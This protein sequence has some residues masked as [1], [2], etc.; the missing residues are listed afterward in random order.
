MLKYTI[1][2]YYLNISREESVERYLDWNYRIGTSH[3]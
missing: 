3:W 1:I 2:L